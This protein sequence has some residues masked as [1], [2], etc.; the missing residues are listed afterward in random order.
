[1]L[2]VGGALLIALV[3]KTFLFQAFYIPSPSMYPTLQQNDRVLVNKLSYKLH[4]VNR[5]DIVVFTKPP[6]L[7]SDIHDLVKRVIA[8]PGETVE[9]HDGHVY[10]DGKRLDESYLGDGITTAGFEPHDVPANAVWVMGDNRNA[11]KDSREFGA[12]RESSI[13]G[14]VFIRIWPISRIGFL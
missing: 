13:V 8:L 12:I 2:L 4:D 1:V 9:G 5:G 7:E 14:R 10:V 6:T 11:S 3:V